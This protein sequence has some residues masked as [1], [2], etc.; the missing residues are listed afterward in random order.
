MGQLAIAFLDAD[1]LTRWAEAEQAGEEALQAKR[2]LILC[3]LHP[4][5]AQASVNAFYAEL[6]FLSELSIP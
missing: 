4:M 2:D 3:V 5:H 6:F 1:E